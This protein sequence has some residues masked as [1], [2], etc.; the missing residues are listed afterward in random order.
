[1][2]MP[3]IWLILAVV[4][5]VVELSTAALVSVWL[6]PSA[7]ITALVAL[8]WDSIA[9]QI[10]IFV[11]LSVVSLVI[12]NKFYRAKL[13]KKD[14]SLDADSRLIGRGATATEQISA[15]GGK[16]LVGDVYWRAVSEEDAV[17]ESG[18]KV[19]VKSVNGTTLVVSKK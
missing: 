11:V 4:F 9:A 8:V 15:D 3:L 13:K 18:E 16:V 5:L 6:I 19:T 7:L 1:M 12:F 10:I 17:I 14:A 2:P